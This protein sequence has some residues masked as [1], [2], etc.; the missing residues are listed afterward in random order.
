LNEATSPL[1]DSTELSDLPRLS[2]AIAA[3]QLLLLLPVEYVSR[4]YR[5]D[6]VKRGMV[7]DDLFS[8]LS[9]DSDLASNYVDQS[10]TILRTFLQRVLTH[11]DYV[12]QPV[13]LTL[14]GHTILFIGLQ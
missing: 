2:G 7:A 1:D 3:Y 9:F 6:F 10:L 11:V 14:S 8:H 13:G 4:S 5:P 12:E